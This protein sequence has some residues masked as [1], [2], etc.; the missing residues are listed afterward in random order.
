MESIEHLQ[1]DVDR[2]T[3]LLDECYPGWADR[4][5]TDWLDLESPAH[6]VLG[7]LYGDYLGAREAL[8]SAR[9]GRVVHVR[10]DHVLGDEYG[11]ERGR[12]QL[13]L[14]LYFGPDSS[15]A[16]GFMAPAGK[17]HFYPVLTSLWRKAIEDRT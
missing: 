13:N 15:V 7:Q 4:I 10:H 8:V 1:T 3:A 9:G 17:S 11:F 6:C 12:A 16:H 5:D 2:G 14:A